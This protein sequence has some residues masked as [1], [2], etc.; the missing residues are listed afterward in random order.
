MHLKIV[1]YTVHSFLNLLETNLTQILHDI[2]PRQGPRMAFVEEKIYGSLVISRFSYTLANA[3]FIATPDSRTLHIANLLLPPENA[4]SVHFVIE[5]THYPLSKTMCL[6]K[7]GV[8]TPYRGNHLATK[9]VLSGLQSFENY[10][11]PIQCIE[12]S[13]EHYAILRLLLG[14]N[15]V[16]FRH[17]YDAN[18]DIEVMS[19]KKD[20]CQHKHE[21]PGEK[22]VVINATSSLITIQISVNNL[23]ALKT[24]LEIRH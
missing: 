9:A 17:Y 22:K 10:P 5:W 20:S 19:Q 7:L 6:S 23:T 18:G 14:E 13:C 1:A 8:G 11:Y 12:A 24:E 4:M 2:I 16:L 21:F 3:A 15:A